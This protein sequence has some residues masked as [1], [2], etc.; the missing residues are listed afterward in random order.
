[1]HA[2]KLRLVD[3]VA[4]RHTGFVRKGNKQ[5][6]NGLT[7]KSNAQDTCAC[8]GRTVLPGIVHMPCI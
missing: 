8:E 5:K 6:Q 2:A 3:R 1:M 7:A 4:P